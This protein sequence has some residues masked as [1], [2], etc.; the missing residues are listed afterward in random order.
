MRGSPERVAE[1]LS[2]DFIEVG[3]SGRIYDRAAAISMLAG[4]AS[5]QRRIEAF[6]A[7]AVSRSVVLVTYRAVRFA[8][9]GSP[10]ARSRRSSLWRREKGEWRMVFHQGTPQPFA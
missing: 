6:E 9:D 8:E 7:R 2:A 5:A 1:L 4:G 10:A 3:A